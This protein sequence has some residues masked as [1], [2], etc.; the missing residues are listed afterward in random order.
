MVRFKNKK[1]TTKQDGL[2]RRKKK[3]VS[4][5]FRSSSIRFCH[6]YLSVILFLILHPH[7][8]SKRVGVIVFS[9]MAIGNWLFPFLFWSSASWCLSHLWTAHLSW[10]CVKQEGTGVT[11]SEQ[12]GSSC[13]SMHAIRQPKSKAAQL[14]FASPQLGLILVSLHYHI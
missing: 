11:V 9:R 8:F 5:P 13:Y 12:S 7:V 6:M 14:P 4:W 3:K 2:K 10:L 1:P